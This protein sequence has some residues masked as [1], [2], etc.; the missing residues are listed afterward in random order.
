MSVFMCRSIVHPP[1]QMFQL[2]HE[3]SGNIQTH[4]YTGDWMVPFLLASKTQ[5]W[6]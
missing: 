1:V 6:K 2:V 3:V 4:N 5:G